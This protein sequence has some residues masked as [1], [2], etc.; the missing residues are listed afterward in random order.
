MVTSQAAVTPL[1]LMNHSGGVVFSP[2]RNYAADDLPTL[3]QILEG[4]PPATTAPVRVDR[5]PGTTFQYSNAGF[6]VL[7]LLIEDVTGSS[8]AEVVQERVFDPVGMRHSWVEAPLPDDALALER[9]ESK[10]A[11]LAAY[12]TLAPYGGNIEGVR[13]AS[14]AWFGVG[15]GLYIRNNPAS[16]S[17]G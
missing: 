7:R 3:M 10:D 6:E 2:P 16:Q 4:L 12:L 8:F 14:L 1:R 9:L 13:A 17:P 5:V 15:A 11:I